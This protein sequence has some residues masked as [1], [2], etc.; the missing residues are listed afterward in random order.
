[1]NTDSKSNYDATEGCAA[2][3]G[4]APEDDDVLTCPDCE[5]VMKPRKSWGGELA[6]YC[7]WDGR[8]P[9]IKQL[10]AMADDP[11]LYER[12]RA[13]AR[14]RLGL[15]CLRRTISPAAT[16]SAA[17]TVRPARSLS[18]RGFWCPQPA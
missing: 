5:R 2:M 15:P 7:L 9:S 17:A 10:E 14:E 6:C 16:R 1:M 12:K 3:A 18:R 13:I 4:Y 11:D 8:M